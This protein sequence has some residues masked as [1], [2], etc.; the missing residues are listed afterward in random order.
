MDNLSVEH[1]FKSSKIRDVVAQLI[2]LDYMVQGLDDN[3]SRLRKQNRELMLKNENKMSDLKVFKSVLN[4]ILE[5]KMEV[6]E[7]LQQKGEEPHH[8]IMTEIECYKNIINLATKQLD[9]FCQD[10]LSEL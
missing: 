6:V 4:S 10:R 8:S 9:R 7:R 3:N 5:I 1:D 2:S